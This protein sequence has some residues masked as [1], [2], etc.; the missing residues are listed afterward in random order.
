MQ[1]A[2]ANLQSRPAWPPRPDGSDADRTLSPRPAVVWRRAEDGSIH[3]I[4]RENARKRLYVK[5][6]LWTSDHLQ[7]LGCTFNYRPA[8]SWN[9]QERTRRHPLEPPHARENVEGQVERETCES[10]RRKRAYNLK[11]RLAYP[12]L[13]GA[14]I[15]AL[16][17]ILEAYDIHPQR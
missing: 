14:K 11:V 5:P 9:K 17:Q 1:E 15:S 3:S 2:E 4:L 8:R 16:N 6:I 13:L 12:S 10:P 7:L